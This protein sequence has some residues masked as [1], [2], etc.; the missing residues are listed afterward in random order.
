VVATHPAPVRLRALKY[1]ARISCLCD[2]ISGHMNEL[3]A[4]DLDGSCKVAMVTEVFADCTVTSGPGAFWAGQKELYGRCRM[5][6]A[7]AV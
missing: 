5:I 6:S 7:V 1:F 4:R 3:I 2:D